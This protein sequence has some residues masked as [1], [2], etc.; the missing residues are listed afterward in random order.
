MRAG[1]SNV[2]G[3]ARNDPV[4]ATITAMAT[5]SEILRKQ[6]KARGLDQTDIARA[7]GVDV[8]TV[9]RWE[10]G[11]RGFDFPVTAG[12]VAR[13]LG[14]TL[15]ELAGI[16]PIG[17]ELSGDWHARWRTWRYGNEVID[18][19]PMAIT[20][21][22]PRVEMDS[23]GDYQWRAEMNIVGYHLD[24]TYRSIEVD[25][26]FHGALHLWLS[27]DA[28]MMI[29]HWSG[30]FFDGPMGGDWGVIARD[31]DKAEA[32]IRWLSEHGSAPLLEWPEL[33]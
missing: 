16:T 18:R 2:N 32:M 22:G 17:I 8:R 21:T 6:R 23:T 13:A 27:E 15:D 31:G 5:Y 30:S 20:Q 7:A 1:A 10:R 24:G 9:Q 12:K 4:T 11:E 19:H 29:G 26:Q 25:R 14:L 28:N 3:F 33:H